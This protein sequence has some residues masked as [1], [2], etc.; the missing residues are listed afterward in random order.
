MKFKQTNQ[1]GF[2]KQIFGFDIETYDDNKEF[3]CASI[4]YD[5]NNYFFTK[6]K[7]ALIN[8]FKKKQFHNTFVCATNL[9]FDFNGTFYNEPEIDKFSVLYRGS[10][11]LFAS[12]YLD[13]N[14][15]MYTDSK[16]K[17]NQSRNRPL[18][19]IDSM[20]YA[21]MSVNNM[22]K[23][24]KIPKLDTPDC[25]GEKP[26]TNSEWEYMKEYNIRDSLISMKF[27]KF[28]YDAFYDL[29]ATPKKTIAS[30][31]MSLY[32]NKYITGEYHTKSPIQLK[33]QFLGYY[34][35]RTEAFCRGYF[36]DFNYY[37]FNSLYPAVMTNEYP[38]PN[39]QRISFKNT[40]EFI[41]QYEG[42]SFVQVTT[43]ADCHYPLL[44]YRIP[45]KIIFPKGSFTGAYTHIELRKALKLGYRIDKVFKTYY[46][47]KTCT[48][49]K[50]Y[51][52]D[53]YKLRLQYKNEVDEQ[54]NKKENPME[55]VVKILMNS[56]YGK[57]GQ[58]FENKEMWVHK[59]NLTTELL[60]KYDTS[61]Q[62]GDFYKLQR[63]LP[64][65]LY[66][67]PIWAAYTT[68]MGRIKLHEAIE[69]CEPLY[70]DTDSL[71]TKKKLETSDKLGELKLEM[72]IKEGIIVKPK[73]YATRSEGNKDYVKIKGVTQSWNLME[74]RG[75]LTNPTVN[76]D[77]FLKFKEAVRRDMIPNQ[78]VKKSKTLSL[79]DNKRMWS[80]NFNMNKLQMSEPRYITHDIIYERENNKDILLYNKESILSTINKFKKDSIIL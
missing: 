25:I 70:C 23:I 64:P 76:Q 44:P 7:R 56:L 50:D 80:A 29:G 45:G 30:T 26:K 28:L 51:V 63:D 35:G 49:Y 31:A 46:Y 61:Y 8:E 73:F 13:H 77:K 24:L 3:L 55:Y 72:K 27:L 62:S 21:M 9:A 4:V 52:L 53:L 68:A 16:N 58:K 11:L 79:E 74:F 37:D 57:F 59:N 20:N 66:C 22:G 78:I 5:E 17:I 33:E 47:L 43:P 48:P 34:G 14:G 71:I 36:E 69:D 75:F 41:E 39:S 42:M 60:N 32:T 1:T 67:I 40:T 54:G 18:T 12:T 65:S 15:N 19:F 6:N 38:D 2:R 10:S